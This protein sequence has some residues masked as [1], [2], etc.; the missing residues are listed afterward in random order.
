MEMAELK[1]LRFA[2]RAMEMD[3]I[4]YEYIDQR[5]SSGWTLQGQSK[6][7]EIEVVW[8]CVGKRCWVYWEKDAEDEAAR[9]EAKRKAKV[10]FYRCGKRRHAGGW[11]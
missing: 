1:K 5:D 11:L 3:R 6:R 8:I 7:G 9:Q 10:E 2:L 4:K